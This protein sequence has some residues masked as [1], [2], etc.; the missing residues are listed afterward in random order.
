[1]KREVLI[2]TNIILRIRWSCL[3][4]YVTVSAKVPRELREEA[5]KLGIRISEF[6]RR[7][8]E[9]EVRRRKIEVLKEELNSISTV[10]DK[11]DVDRIVRHIR[12]DRE[13][14]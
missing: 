9:E 8:L 14:R 7:A 4:R 3:S 6:L 11:I 5:E 10:L 12:E 1:M 2:T 13:V